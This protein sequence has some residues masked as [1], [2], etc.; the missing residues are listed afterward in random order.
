MLQEAILDLSARGSRTQTDKIHGAAQ[1]YIS[2]DPQKPSL[3]S[4]CDANPAS[5]SWV[6]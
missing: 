6:N 2:L 1:I 4:L 3:G 5:L